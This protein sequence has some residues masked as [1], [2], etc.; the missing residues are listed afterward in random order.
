MN[1]LKRFLLLLPFL[2]AATLTLLTARAE[3][4]HRNTQHLIGYG[5]LFGAPWSWFIDRIAFLPQFHSYA[6]RA[7]IG[8]IFILWIPAG[9][10][11]ASLWLL[12]FLIAK[13]RK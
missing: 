10:Y 2:I 8:Y 11:S 4:A 3:I 6:L 7:A 13:L 12:F 1:W 9:L 5:F